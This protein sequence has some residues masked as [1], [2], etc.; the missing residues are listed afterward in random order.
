VLLFPS[1]DDSLNEKCLEMYFLSVV[2]G[3]L[4]VEGV[5]PSDFPWKYVMRAVLYEGDTKASPDHDKEA[6]RSATSSGIRRG[7]TVMFQDC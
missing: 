6:E 4:R 7:M 1:P 3:C 5:N 2:G